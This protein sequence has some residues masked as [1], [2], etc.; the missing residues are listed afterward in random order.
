M[1]VFNNWEKFSPFSFSIFV[2]SMH[3]VLIMEALGIY[4]RFLTSGFQNFI[5]LNLLK[6]IICLIIM[7][8][9]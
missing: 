1:R 4:K 3:I 9:F 6:C 7:D 2:L 8:E 5:K